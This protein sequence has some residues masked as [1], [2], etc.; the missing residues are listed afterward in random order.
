M[1]SSPLILYRMHGRGLCGLLLVTEHVRGTQ[2]RV[3]G[4]ASMEP[5]LCRQCS[6]F[7]V[8]GVICATELRES[9]Y[10]FCG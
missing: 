10:Y 5:S 3:Q 6:A 4:V 8:R 9:F 1:E 2:C 7:C